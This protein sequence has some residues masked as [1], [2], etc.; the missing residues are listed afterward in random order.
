MEIDI[1][2]K[3][4]GVGIEFQGEQHYIGVSQ[5]GGITATHQ[6]MARDHMKACQANIF[7]IIL[8]TIPYN[9]TDEKITSLLTE[10]KDR[11]IKRNDN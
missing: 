7:G 5:F 11:L 4:I 8:V 6:Q 9:Y 3:S 2:M 10:I 1:F